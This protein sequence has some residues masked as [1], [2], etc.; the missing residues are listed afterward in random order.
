MCGFLG[1]VAT[2]SQRACGVSATPFQIATALERI[3]YR[4]PDGSRMAFL[5]PRSGDAPPLCVDTVQ[6][7]A[8]PDLFMSDKP[9][10]VVLGHNRLAVI[11]RSEQ[12]AQPMG[13][14]AQN[15][16]SPAAGNP[17]FWLV[18]NGE[19]YNYRELRSDLMAQGV[20]FIT[21]SDSEVL[22]ALYERHGPA[23]LEKL[24]GIF[25]F[26]VWDVR[27]QR[28]FLARDR[29]GTKPLYYTRLAGG[30]FAFA[31]ET[32]SLLALPGIGKSLDYSALSEQ[33]TFQTMLADRTLL[34]HIRLLE[35]GCY[36]LLDAE[37]G[38][39]Q[40]TRYWE[41]ILEPIAPMETERDLRNTAAQLRQLL[42]QAVQRQLTGDVPM[43]SLLSGGLDSAAITTI[44]ARLSPAPWPTFTAGFEL[45]ALQP[46]GQNDEQAGDERQ[47]AWDLSNMLGTRHRELAIDANVLPQCLESVVWHL[48]DFRA[49]ISY[50]NYL[51]N[52]M[53]REDVTVVLSGV[54]GDELFAGYPWR[55]EPLL[56]FDDAS[57]VGGVSF[58]N[59]YYQ[60]WIRLLSES[61]KETLFT[62]DAW[63]ALAGF[64]THDSFSET[65]STCQATRPIDRA[66]CFDFKTFLPALLLVEDRLSMA[67]GLESRVPF[68]D[69]DLVDACL[70]LSASIKLRAQTP[71][72]STKIAKWIL[73][74]ALKDL[75][76]AN[77]LERRKQ[78]F[79]PPDAT[80]YRGAH[81]PYIESVL[82]SPTSLERGLFRPE[83]L[84]ALL[85]EH[86]TG[87]KNRRF[88]I[89]S[90]LCLEIW[91][92]Q[93]GI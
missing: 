74:E 73:K 83:A 75:L 91:H 7:I 44:V 68:L 63:Q 19:I 64:S 90:L 40:H 61:E 62:P 92:R 50:P 57:V 77:V 65:L 5:A 82:L 42:E 93:H 41:P 17:A 45:D 6:V 4:G 69:N 3:R 14:L 87:S 28:V 33:L 11:D 30:D 35:P 10:S 12:S 58:E 81:R 38:H 79:T 55:Y 22:L 34:K 48:D 85:E 8:Q 49:G 72:Q 2:G 9:P 51:V 66:L 76:P 39:W 16:N 29:Y 84:K 32:K 27:R 71:E 70:P 31:S 36:A 59:H 54:G 53:A 26:A 47:A 52:R 80:W 46:G 24:N 86:F 15:A 89:W 43:G 67:H 60:A 13:W 88:L 21:E 56:A 1:L 18:Y 20:Q 25:A 37:T 78:G 23:M